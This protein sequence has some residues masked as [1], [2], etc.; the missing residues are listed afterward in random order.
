[1][2]VRYEPIRVGSQHW[3]VATSVP[4]KEMTAR[5]DRLIQ[6]IVVISFIGLLAVAGLILF[7]TSQIA[8]PIKA[9]ADLGDTMAQGDFRQRLPEK[10]LKRRDEIG[11]MANSLQKL[12]EAMK[13]MIGQV[14]QNAMQVAAAAQQISATT[15]E[16]A[17]ASNNQATDT[18]K[19]SEMFIELNDATQLV[20][21]NARNA[22]E[23]SDHSLRVAKE[24]GAMI[25]QSI[26]NMRLVFERI[27]TLEQ[28]SVKIG[29]IT[30]VIEDIAEQTNL[31]AL[32]A[33]IEAA[34]AGEQGRGFAVVADEVR[35]LAERSAEAT[36]QITNIIKQMQQNTKASVDA[37]SEG[38]NQSAET[39]KA[40]R[41]IMD[42][43]GET[44]S[45]VSEIVTASEQQARQS[46]D[47]MSAIESI[48]SASE[49]S[50]AAAEETAATSQSL[51]ELADQ[52]TQSV[53]RFKI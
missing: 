41:Q 50:A 40:F 9:V 49:E 18:Q 34:R 33:A 25:D 27:S 47:V 2:I 32:N 38:V 13:A 1:M 5:T 17:G 7:V 12:A 31:L 45:K 36:Q 26:S 29:D 24:G 23:L 21:Q 30:D 37:V 46:E 19:M 42:M 43:V 52:L 15:E 6:V 48:A 11:I 22:A 35:K 16:I 10:L 39:E 4:I 20:M 8:N 53:D 28:D 51:S 3:S 44:A 14:S